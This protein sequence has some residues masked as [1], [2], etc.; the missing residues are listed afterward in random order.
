MMRAVISLGTNTVRLLVVRDLANGEIEQIE[1]A[2]VGTR[3]GEGVTEAGELAPAAM[4]RTLAAVR[5]FAERARAHGASLASIATSAVRRAT[6]Q[7]AFAARMKAVTG[8]P[9]RVLPGSVEAEASFRG[10]TYGAPADGKRIAVIDIGGGSTEAAS[11][12]NGVIDAALSLEIGSVR[13]SERH[14]DLMGRSPG[15]PARRAALAARADAAAVVRP[16]EVFRGTAQVR[17][18]AGTPLTIAAVLQAS[19]VDRVSGTTLSR[20]EAD[21]VLDRLLELG[22]DERRALPGMLPQRADVLAGGAIILSEV[23]RA[24]DVESVL[25]EANDLLLGFLLLEREST[26]ERRS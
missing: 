8:V 19:H 5:T 3:L 26:A 10:A 11:G 9:L 20:S 1:H 15:A 7:D 2:Q 18:V 6:N 13:L 25:L 17:A 23:L 22:L 12:Q 14:P 4:E 21:A 24:L 16:F